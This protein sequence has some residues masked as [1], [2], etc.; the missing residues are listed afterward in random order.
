MDLVLEQFFPYNTVKRFIY[1]YFRQYYCLNNSEKWRYLQPIFAILTLKST[2]LLFLTF[3]EPPSTMWQ[4]IHTD[5]SRLTNMPV[6]VNLVFISCFTQATYYLY[7]NYFEKHRSIDFLVSTLTESD[8]DSIFIS[9]Y[10][11]KGKRNK[12]KRF[13]VSEH[14]RW[15]CSIVL[16]LVQVFIITIRK[17]DKV[18]CFISKLCFKLFCIFAQI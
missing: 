3:Y 14:I 1:R 16:G 7:L 10:Y 11:Q 18:V 5:L 8:K 4:L 17:N 9:K 13:P 2:H 6:E 15:Y 12:F